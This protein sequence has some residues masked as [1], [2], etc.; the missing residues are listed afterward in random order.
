MKPVMADADSIQPAPPKRSFR[1][2]DDLTLEDAVDPEFLWNI[3]PLSVG[4]IIAIGNASFYVELYV[5]GID[6]EEREVDT[7]ILLARDFTE[8][9]LERGLLH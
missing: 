2:D 9:E 6:L 1:A 3:E 8:P 5:T 7:E 4:E